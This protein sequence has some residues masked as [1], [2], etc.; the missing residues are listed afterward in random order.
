MT[1]DQSVGLMLLGVF[2][3]P[4]AVLGMNV[5]VAR[6]RGIRG[7]VDGLKLPAASDLRWR[8]IE[9][10]GNGPCVYGF[11]DIRVRRRH[12]WEPWRLDGHPSWAG[13]AY[14]AQVARQQAQRAIDEAM[15]LEEP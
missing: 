12:Y 15:M 9:R 14:A 5:A 4:A 11:G 8:V 2:G 7:H 10:N 1:A 6:L 3:I 13:D